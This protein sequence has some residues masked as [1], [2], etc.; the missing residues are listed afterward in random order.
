MFNIQIKAF[1]DINYSI[2]YELNSILYEKLS[3]Y[4]FYVKK[5]GALKYKPFV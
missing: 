4:N 3:E 1:C 5:I 2:K